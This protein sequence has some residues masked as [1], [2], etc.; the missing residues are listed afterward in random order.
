[1]KEGR[2]GA[3]TYDISIVC[4]MQGMIPRDGSRGAMI[5]ENQSES[6]GSK[7]LPRI[8]GISENQ[9][10]CREAEPQLYS[11]ESHVAFP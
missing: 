4:R 11:H 5:S 2:G 6:Q 9:R 1:M 7:G 10:E 8:E 3:V